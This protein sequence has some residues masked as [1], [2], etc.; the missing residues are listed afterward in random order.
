MGARETFSTSIHTGEANRDF[1]GDA[2]NGGGTLIP[3]NTQ[4]FPSVQA[5]ESA[6]ALGQI[7]QAQR[8][9]LKQQT[10][11]HAQAVASN[12]KA[13]LRNSGDYFSV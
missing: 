2:G 10:Q 9:A 13:T 11:M 5:I 1:A 8:V 7:T 12:A 3:N 4:Q 6:F